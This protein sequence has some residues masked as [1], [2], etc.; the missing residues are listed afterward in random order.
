VSTRSDSPPSGRWRSR[1]WAVIA[2]ASTVAVA[3][4]MPATA[5]ASAASPRATVQVRAIHPQ[6]MTLTRVGTVNFAALAK[7]AAASA[8]PATPGKPR[9]LPLGKPPLKN[10]GSQP[11]SS[12]RRAPVA[13]LTTI[14]PQSGTTGV[15][16]FNGID[17]TTSLNVNGFDVT[18]PD[19]GMATGTSSQ[20]T[21]VVQSLNLAVQAFSPSGKTLAGPVSLNAFFGLTPDWFTSD[22][23][24]YWDPQTKHWFLTM[25]TVGPPFGGAG[26]SSQQFIAVSQTT[27]AL[28]NYTIFSIPTQTS[29]IDNTQCPCLG[30]FDMIG[31]DN[32]GF[33]ITTNEFGI[34]GVGGGF[35]GTNL[36]ALS[37]AG[38]IAA[39]NG[40]PLPT[41]FHYPIPTLSDPFGAYHLAPSSVTQGSKVPNTEYFVESDGNDF[42]NSALEVWALT[43]TDLLNSTGPTLAPAA[44]VATEG[45]ST[46]PNAVQKSGPIPFGNTQGATVASPLETDFDAVQ[47]VTYASGELYAQLSTGVSAGGGAAN[48]GVAWFALHPTAGSGTV[49]V[50][51]DGNGYVQVNGHLLYPS[52]GVAANGHGYMAFALS[53]GSDFPTAAYIKFDDDEGAVGPVLIQKAGTASLDDL[54]CYPALA[55]PGCRYGDY[56][57]TQ[58]YNGRVYLAAEY[59]HSLTDVAGGA[60]ANWGTRIWSVPVPGS[61]NG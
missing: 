47:L 57:A 39:A 22:P 16:G 25:L 23:R 49:S 2:A 4:S 45:Y 43:S 10:A 32:S 1:R 33:Y 18:P 44:T 48:A 5:F 61:I 14:V 26:T 51:N 21:A 28:G 13:P 58:V 9:V 19:M 50:K 59:I 11:K 52:I 24:V 34:P 40:A 12:A 54:S 8:S 37:K 60:A 30:D 41:L 35:N 27:D 7:K 56:S 36:Y 17:S 15:K 55:G 46:P 6:A 42:S 29:V 20:G 53:S 38:L 3:V 31:A